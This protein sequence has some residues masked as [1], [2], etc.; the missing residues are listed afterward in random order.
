MELNPNNLPRLLTVAIGRQRS[1]QLEPW[2]HAV[3]EA[4]HGADPVASNGEDVQAS[5]VADAAR[6]AQIGFERRLTVGSCPH[7]IEP[8]A[9]AEEAGAE[10]GHDISALIFEWHRWHRDENVVR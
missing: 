3:L 8:P 2:E 5:P 10:A 6:S 7:E 9:R 1:R 4:G